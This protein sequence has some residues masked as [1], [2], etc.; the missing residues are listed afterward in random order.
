MLFDLKQLRQVLFDIEIRTLLV[1][2][3]HK[4]CYLSSTIFLSGGCYQRGHSG[5]LDS[6]E[7]QVWDQ[8]QMP[9]H[10]L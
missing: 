3:K 9:K 2:E 7:L 5:Q 10:E 6:N 4:N 8:P 1:A